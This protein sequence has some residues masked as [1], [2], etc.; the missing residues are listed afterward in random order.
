MTLKNIRK[1]IKKIPY[2]K[3]LYQEFSNNFNK[4]KKKNKYQE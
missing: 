1:F 4:L 3:I 2:A